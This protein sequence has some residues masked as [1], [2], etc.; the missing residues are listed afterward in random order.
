[1]AV[2]DTVENAISGNTITIF[3]KTWCPYCRRAKA[4]IASEFAGTKTQ[5]LELDTLDEGDDI[6]NYLY[7]KT[8]QRSVPNIFINQKHVGGC[9]KVVALHSQGELAPLVRA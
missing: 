5:I 4:L 9:D 8:G 6:Q 1:M 2:K 7:E 3:S